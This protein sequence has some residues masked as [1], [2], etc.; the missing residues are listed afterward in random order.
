[1]KQVILTKVHHAASEKTNLNKGLLTNL[2]SSI[3]MMYMKHSLRCR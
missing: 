1:M 3:V 2:A